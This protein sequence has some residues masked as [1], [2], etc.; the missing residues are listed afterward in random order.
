[1]AAPLVA[2]FMVFVGRDTV[3]VS[4]VVN[5]KKQTT[6][7]VFVLRTVK[8]AAVSPFLLVKKG[9]GYNVVKIYRRYRGISQV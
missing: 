9:R 2:V 3:P 7:G 5:G 4:N 1:M 6:E 8:L